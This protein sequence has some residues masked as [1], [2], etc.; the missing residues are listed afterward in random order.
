VTGAILVAA[1]SADSDIAWIGVNVME[2]R[3]LGAGIGAGVS[4]S[5]FAPGEKYI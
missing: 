3:R 5:V 1:T 4:T 2:A